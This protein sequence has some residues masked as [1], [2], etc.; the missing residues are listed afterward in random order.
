MTWTS[1]NVRYNNVLQA[2]GAAL[3]NTQ[4][5]VDMIT[6]DQLHLPTPCEDWDVEMLIHH[7][8]YGN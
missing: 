2:Q 8:V 3:Q 6:V 4:A 1:C 7:I 5:I